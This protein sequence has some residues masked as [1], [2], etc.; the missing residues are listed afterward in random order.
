MKYVTLLLI[1]TS[2]QLFAQ[3]TQKELKNLVGIATVYSN[4]QNLQGDFA[5]NIKE[6]RDDKTTKIVDR[7]IIFSKK[8]SAVLS[9]EVLTRPGRE[10]LKYWSA[11][12][13]IFRNKF[14]DQP[15]SVSNHELAE[16]ALA[17]ELNVYSTLHDFYGVARTAIGFA[18]N[19]HD[20][21]TINI[22]LNQ[23]DLLDDCEKG[24]AFL[25]LSQG[26]ITRFRVLNMMGNTTKILEFSNNLPSFNHQPYYEFTAFD[27]KDFKIMTKDGKKSF[28]KNQLNDYYEALLAHFIAY[29]DQNKL[30]EG[31][32]FFDR[33]ILSIRQYFKY[34]NNKRL[35]KDLQ[36]KSQ[37]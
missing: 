13:A 2:F 7:L 25:N 18:F 37:K 20:L 10:E 24:I 16:E 11:I 15:R 31:R 4:N 17:S 34:S 6:F 22:D 8:D 35:L 14:S 36:K 26:M 30:K 21:S 27:F 5:Q 1:T 3:V 12:F 23:L 29:S 33:S 28:L 19:T 9:Q 32:Q